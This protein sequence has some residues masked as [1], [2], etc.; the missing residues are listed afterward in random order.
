MGLTTRKILTASE[1]EAAMQRGSHRVD[2]D[3]RK[4]G[5]I[6][7]WRKQ[8]AAKPKETRGEFIESTVLSADI[9]QPSITVLKRKVD[10]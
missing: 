4:A 2:E 8:Q 7:A 6:D 1:R 3:I 9:G 10:L 5:G